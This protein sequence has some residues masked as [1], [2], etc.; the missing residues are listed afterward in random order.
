MG[1]S[2]YLSYSVLKGI[3]GISKNKGTSLWHCPKLR[4]S[5][6]FLRHIDR[7]KVSWT[8]LDKVEAQSMIN[9]TDVGQL[10]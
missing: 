10:S 8:S 1:A 5:K 6:I 2:F 4:T 7:R 3:S 9:W